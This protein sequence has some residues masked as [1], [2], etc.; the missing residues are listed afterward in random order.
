MEQGA[1][2]NILGLL[3]S[4]SGVDFTHYKEAILRRRI[5][6]R[7]TTLYLESPED[8]ES[9]LREHPPEIQSLLN[10]V[11]TMMAGFFRLPAAFKWFRKSHVSER[12][13]DADEPGHPE[14]HETE[15]EIFDRKDWR[16]PNDDFGPTTGRP[17][18]SSCRKM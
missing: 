4:Q 9:Y 17:L 13:D 6:R 10:D 14:T 18:A 7:M 2:G 5:K 12:A 11:L 3:R 15:T 16:V 8:Y 1:I